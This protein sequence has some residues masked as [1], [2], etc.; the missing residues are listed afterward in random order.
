MA[1]VR[2]GDDAA[3][4]E[5]FSRYRDRITLYVRG[6]VGDY[7]RAEDIT[8]EVFISALRRMRA[9][10]RPILFKPWIYEIAKNACI[11]EF[12]RSRRTTEVS[13]NE[14]GE[15]VGAE[16]H[17][18]SPDPLPEVVIE[19]RQKLRNLRGAFGGLS[20][21]HHRI[22]VMRELEGLS[23]GEIG[24]QLGMSRAMVESTLFRARKRLNQE[25]REL[26]S[27]Q[28]CERVRT[29]IDHSG[30]RSL[31]VLGVRERR[32]V[33]RHMAYCQQCR[34][35]AWMAGFDASSLKRRSAA[36]RV[37]ALLPLGWWHG[38]SGGVKH[39]VRAAKVTDKLSRYSEPLSQVGLGRAV[40]AA[41]AIAFAAAGG[42]Y[43]VSQSNPHHSVTTRDAA[44]VSVKPVPAP[45]M[46]AFVR[47]THTV[48]PAVGATAAHARASHPGHKG[49]GAKAARHG[50]GG[51]GHAGTK[52]TAGGSSPSHGGASSTSTEP[53]QYT[54][55]RSHHGG[56]GRGL[57]GSLLGGGGSSSGGR[58]STPSIPSLPRTSLHGPSS[59]SAPTRG[60]VKAA[61]Q[62][63]GV[64][65][66]AVNNAAQ[67]VNSVGG[68]A[69]KLVGGATGLGGS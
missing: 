29:T 56:T 23:Y 48:A 49:K 12:R 9:T 46:Q 68:K 22:L 36:Q 26:E 51:K 47:A 11:D 40:A 31:R 35:Y 33:A 69:E 2:E 37:A 45:A 24:Q 34:Q 28:R 21:N 18:P 67:T 17:L 39:M 60:A 15:S 57:L 27:G 64:A 42:G 38:R 65:T 55:S 63:A 25:Y 58:L 53:A 1:A 7:A 19:E 10:E 30:L 43:A 61:T 16:L 4:E 54:T 13:L 41:A 14:D 6:A 52:P 3:F 62:A 8:Q 5:L 20:E 44:A 59:I 66:Q 32:Q 50:A